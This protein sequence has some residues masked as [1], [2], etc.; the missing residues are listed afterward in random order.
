MFTRRLKIVA[1][2][3]I[4]GMSQALWAQSLETRASKTEVDSISARL[5]QLHAQQA[6][7]SKR[8]DSLAQ[9]I[10][11]MKTQTASPSSASALEAA[12][13]T[14]KIWADA[15]QKTQAEEQFLDQALRQKAETLL[16]NLSNDLD[17]LTS[18]ANQAA[19]KKDKQ[20][21]KQLQQEL[22]LCRQWQE[23]CQK[24]LENPPTKIL[25]YEVRVDPEDDTQALVRKADFLR[26]QSD[27]LRR[28]TERLEQKLAELRQE[29]SLR[30]R[31]REFEQEIVL[32]E[33]SNEG[34]REGRTEQTSSAFGTGISDRDALDA[35]TRRESSSFAGSVVFAFNWPNNIA[36]LSM[37]DLNDWIKHLQQTQKRLRAQADSLRQRA[38]AVESLRPTPQK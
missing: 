5:T 26:D 6:L 7:M 32:L 27:R 24:V 10:T 31:M 35:Q 15:L 38:T 16:K 22:K 18:A 34:M 21:G 17:R 28:E 9:A 1:L 3:G 4:L 33:P 29:E 36:N 25:I 12:L 19:Q 20:L 2:G 14:S 13:R 30:A 8:A 23:Q 11:R 37:Q